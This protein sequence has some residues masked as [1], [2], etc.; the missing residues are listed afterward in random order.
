MR[1]DLLKIASYWVEKLSGLT[2]NVVVIGNNSSTLVSS[3]AKEF[4]NHLPQTS[5]VIDPWRMYKQDNTKAKIYQL[6]LGMVN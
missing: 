6:G 1:T 5:L 3:E 4:L 2:P